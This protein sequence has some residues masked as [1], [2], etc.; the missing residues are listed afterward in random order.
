MERTV[1]WRHWD[2]PDLRNTATLHLADDHLTATGRQICTEYTAG[3]SLRTS[4]R[5]ITEQ[6]TVEVEAAG[7][8]RTLQLQRTADGD[9]SDHTTMTGRQPADWPRPG[10]APGTDLSE[11]F[12]CDLGLCPATNTM[13]ILRLGLLHRT[14]PRTP[15]IMAWI[16]MPSLRVIASDQYYASAS[17]SSVAYS[18]GT[19]GVDVTLGVDRD[20]IVMDY[21]QLARRVSPTRRQ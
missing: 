1:A 3:W 7:W 12:D 10:I 15:L 2:D 11:A 14:V 20:G 19:R 18:S 4:R 5:W 21:P 8:S 9:W 16:D 13:P 6:V 17:S